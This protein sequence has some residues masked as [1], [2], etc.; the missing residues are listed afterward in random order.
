MFDAL[1]LNDSDSDDEQTF[2]SEEKP[3]QLTK[4]IT[5]QE[6][7]TNNHEIIKNIKQSKQEKQTKK[8]K[9]EPIQK[10]INTKTIYKKEFSL[11]AGNLE[12]FD[13]VDI[14]INE[15]TKYFITGINGCGKTTLLKYL[16]EDM[17]DK[18]DILMIE[19]DIIIE[20]LEET[21]AE[22]ILN[23]NKTLYE[24][25]KEFTIYEN[26]DLNE[27]EIEK[28]NELS[29]YLNIN[30]WEKYN[31]ETNRILNGLGFKNY[32]NKV[33][34]LSGGWRM[35]LA[36]GKALLRKP[37]ILLL[38]EPTNNLSINAII[39][40]T[41]Y[42]QEYK[43]TLIVIT[44]Q[45]NLI[46]TIANVIWYIG[47]PTN[48]KQQLYVINGK[49]YKLKKTLEQIETETLNNYETFQKKVKELQNKSTP[50]K[51]VD[52]FIKLNNVN[53]PDTRTNFKITFP[54]I[55]VFSLKY[56]INIK[57]VDF[58]YGNNEIQ[59]NEIQNNEIY[60]NINLSIDLKTRI[61]LVGENGVG[62]TTLFNLIM[63]KIQPTNGIIIKDERIKIVHYNQQILENL[64]LEKTPLEYL[65]MI[66]PNE[67]ECCACLGKIGLKD[68][69]KNMIINN[70]SGGQKVK[71]SLCYIQLQKPHVI[72]F[73]EV[74]NH[75]DH[76]AIDEIIE[77]I[78][79]YNG[80]VIIITHD[81]YL[82]ESIKNIKI[83]KVE[84]KN[85][86]YFNG[87]FNDYCNEIEY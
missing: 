20:N 21:I 81:I 68:G 59:N 29:E 24:K 70:L 5:K 25:Y 55:N 47:N 66:N 61:V 23:A 41:N 11:N 67:T 80:A 57:D 10:M 58:S 9:K 13:E 37:L 6:E 48:T 42:L 15:K 39:W 8:N 4:Q 79:E 22:F 73:D 2:S 38:D 27:E 18:Q 56:V 16:Y 28:Y 69:K 30:E 84:N 34:N 63:E 86:I 1:S 43:N 12:I 53:R 77:A 62:K 83:Y 60:K 40:L 74:S 17:K 64:P 71:L 76:Y 87:D 14:T 44:H 19:Q 33:N 45:I 54:N 51:Q 32:N 52:E 36:L 50:K 49:Y 3:K 26:K 75:L 31:A 46:D 65:L 85:I 7:I 72:L 35:K 78:N 82:I